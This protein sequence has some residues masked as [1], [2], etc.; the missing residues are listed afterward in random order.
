MITDYPETA[1]SVSKVAL[2]RAG[3]E[4][5]R[6]CARWIGMGDHYCLKCDMAIR[7]TILLKNPSH[8]E[9]LVDE[10]AWPEPTRPSFYVLPNAS[11]LLATNACGPQE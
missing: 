6:S 7:R 11:S 9:Q 1:A 4:R 5:E 10:G 2:A 8:F 3:V